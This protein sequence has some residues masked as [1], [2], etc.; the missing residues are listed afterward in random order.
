MD[1]KKLVKPNILS[2]HAYH[3]EE[4]PCRIKLD[5]NES[6]YGRRVLKTVKTNKYP[7]PEAKA[8]RELVA[9]ELGVKSDCILHGNGSDEI[10][11][12]M[13]MTFGGPV[14][15]PVPT[16][17]MY[18]IISQALG[19]KTIEIPLNADFDIN[20]KSMLK[21]IKKDRPKLVFL[22]SPNNPTGNSFSSE[23]ILKII[24]QSK[25][26]VVVDEAY[27]QFSDRKSFLPLLKKH[28][29]LVVLR[30]LSKIGL[31]GLRVG[32]MVADSKITDEVNKVRLPFNLNS[33]S[34][35][36]AIDS[37][38]NKK[39]MR[40]SIRSIIN[41]RKR[42]FREMAK[43]DSIEPY[44]S[45]ANFILFKTE[46]AEKIFKGLLKRG[47]LIRNM[48]GAVEDCLRVT[49]GTPGGNSAFL[50]TLKQLL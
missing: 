21:A 17:S 15:Y 14:M 4:I 13:I 19:E 29:N 39:Q 37:L 34:Q 26:L 35:K 7:D 50:K 36:V 45:N 27:Q 20:D 43:L 8:L 25:G 41:E 23:K 11:Y 30:T 44:P 49:V 10:I 42:L 46:N 2:I 1:I 47:I 31:A 48:T 38:K 40:T 28:R 18:G 9:K 16:F 5:A 3:A 24:R 32:F 33:L 12:N 22:S 6:P